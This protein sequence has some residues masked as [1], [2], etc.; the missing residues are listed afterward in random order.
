M[1]SSRTVDSCFASDEGLQLVWCLFCAGLVFFFASDDGLLIFA[2]T[3]HIPT[4]FFHILIPTA[5]FSFWTTEGGRTTWCQL[6]IVVIKV[7]TT[8]SAITDI[9][10]SHIIGS[11]IT[12]KGSDICDYS[13]AMLGRQS[14]SPRPAYHCRGPRILLRSLSTASCLTLTFLRPAR[15]HSSGFF[16]RNN[17][18]RAYERSLSSTEEAS[19]ERSVG[20]APRNERGAGTS[21]L[22]IGGYDYS[23]EYTTS[24]PGGYAGDVR[25]GM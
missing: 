17:L 22:K 23:D 2:E 19:N 20:E 24:A 25:T 14:S 12:I 21:F 4:A 11:D 15:G 13:R 16:S 8:V 3:R 7:S 18:K 9:T 5:G 1:A 6:G 10:G